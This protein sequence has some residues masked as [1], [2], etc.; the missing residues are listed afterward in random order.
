M[1][2]IYCWC[3]VYVW[4]YIGYDNLDFVVVNVF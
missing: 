4:C 1:G 2:D 3:F